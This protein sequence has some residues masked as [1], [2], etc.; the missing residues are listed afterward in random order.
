MPNPKN[1]NTV[2]G[3]LFAF[4][5]PLDGCVFFLPPPLALLPFLGAMLQT[6]ECQRASKAKERLDLIL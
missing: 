4:L 6:L 2:G 3:C 5:R 1:P